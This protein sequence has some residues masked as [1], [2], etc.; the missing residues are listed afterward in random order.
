MARFDEVTPDTAFSRPYAADE[1]VT[2]FLRSVYGWMA[3]GLAVTALVAT[4]VA[5]TPELVFTIASNRLIFWG[6]MLSQIGIVVWLSARAATMAPATASMLFLLYSALTGVTMSFLLLAFTGQSIATTFMVTA[7]T[8]GALATYGTVTKRSLAGW[9]QFLFM[10]LIGVVIASVV[11][12][13]WQNDAFQFVLSF[14]GVIVFTGLTAYDA[15]RLKAMALA[16]PNG[17]TGSYAVV[18][19]LTLYLD[20]INLFIMLLRL[21]GTRRS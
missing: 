21:T 9:G 5:G 14:I 3:A 19:A 20:F 16:M 1:R 11:G 17:Q 8:F 13:F 18:G 10:G 15:Q 12:M 7:G 4:V 2:V 6:L